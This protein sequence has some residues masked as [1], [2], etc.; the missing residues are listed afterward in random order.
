MTGPAGYGP[1]GFWAAASTL[2]YR[3]DFENFTN[4]SAPAQQVII[5]DQLSTN[6]DWSTFNV[7][8]IGFGDRLIALPPGTASF[9]TNVAVSY[10]GTNFQVQIQVGINPASGLVTATFRS[11]DPNTSL[12]PPVSIGFLPP[13]DGTGRGQGHV[14]YTIHA[15]AGLPTGVQLRNVAL[16]SFDGQPAIA[17]DQIDDFNPAAGTNPAKEALL[18][19]DAVAPTS[20]VLT[21]PSQ[22]P[23][24]QIPLSWTGADDAGGSGIATYSVSVSDNGGPWTLWVAASSSTAGTFSA[25][26]NH[27]YGFYSVARDNAGNLE[28]AHLAAD[29]TTTVTA[30]PV[31][32]TTVSYSATNLNYGDSFNY[33]ITVRNIGNLNLT[34]VVMSNQVPAELTVQWAYFGRGGCLIGDNWVYWTLGSLARNASASMNVVVTATG[35]GTVTNAIR[36]TD[37]TG[38]AATSSRQAIHISLPQPRLAIGQSNHQSLLNWSD[39][40]GLFALQGTTNLGQQTAWFL[41]S[42]TPALNGSQR[43]VIL[44]PS[45]GNLFFRLSTP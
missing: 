32:N 7:A 3:I 11:I 45:A 43:T 31:L 26:P 42:N 8:E 20:H 14:N 22:S 17:T 1:N 28:Q 44:S 30:A 9:A 10:L 40:S 4:A 25:Q 33:T 5:T 13:E 12:P 15:K 41:I 2:A 21:L 19:I 35:F 39:P 36:C 38:F 27:T 18:T 16:I 34:G 23:S 24:L 29:A 6:Y 37:D